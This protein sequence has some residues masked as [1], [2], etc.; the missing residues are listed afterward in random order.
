MSRF[1][2]ATELKTAATSS[3][4][5]ANSVVANKY[6]QCLGFKPSA[7]EFKA[8]EGTF[9]IHSDLRSR[10]SFSEISLHFYGIVSIISRRTPPP[11]IKHIYA[12]GF[13]INRFKTGLSVSR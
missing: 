12:H 6:L 13:I 3:E 2:L 4:N 11:V 1:Q 5:V 8:F 10:H 9:C 7:Y